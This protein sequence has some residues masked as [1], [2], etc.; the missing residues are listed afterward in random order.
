[1]IPLL[2]P[3]R[4]IRSS[5]T[6]LRRD[7]DDDT[8]DALVRKLL[9]QS[10]DAIPISDFEIIVLTSDTELAR[11]LPHNT[12]LDAGSSLNYAVKVAVESINSKRVALLM[13][14]LPGNSSKVF[15]KIICV[16][17]LFDQYIVPTCDDGVAFAILNRDIWGEGLLGKD[18]Y[19]HILEYCDQLGKQVA[20]HIIHEINRDLDTIDDY[21]YWINRM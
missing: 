19:R 16:H 21:N 4:G 6:R 12:M 13:P 17:H 15:N 20:S 2:I 1:M 3:I 10:L 11:F 14:D 9:M 7:L 8:V 5:M 18:S